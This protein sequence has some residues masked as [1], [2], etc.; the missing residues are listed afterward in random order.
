[1][2]R[3]V[4]A[5]LGSAVLV[6]ACAPASAP[7]SFAPSITGQLITQVVAQANDVGIG[8]SAALDSSGN[9]VVTSILATA[10]LKAGSLPP[11]IVPGQPQPPAVVLAD[12]TKATWNTTSVTPQKLSP[13]EGTAPELVDSNGHA[14]PGVSTS[15][16]IDGQGKDHVV[17]STPSGLF[18]ADDTGGAFGTPVQV[19]KDQAFEGSI[20]VASDGTVWVSFYSG[21]TVKVA[22]RTGGS[23]KTQDV[24]HPGGAPGL[25]AVVT[26]IRVTQGGP[27]VAYGDNGSTVVATPPRGT[28][29]PGTA[30]STTTIAGSGGYGVS[31]ALDKDGNPIVTYYDAQGTIHFA[32]LAGG[33]WSVTDLGTTAPGPNSQGNRSWSTSIAIDDQG[34]HYIAWADTKASQIVLDTDRGGSFKAETVSGGQAGAN[35]TLAVSGMASR[36]H[37]PGTTRTTRTLTWPPLL[38]VG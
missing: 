25:P 34:V 27:V 11:Q 35:P 13:A 2:A 7:P 24:A 31:M 15:L 22:Q 38:P 9:P 32:Q 33:S 21:T 8:P 16:A 30:W 23:W 37:W 19:T 28:V 29:K 18:Y 26:A 14:L 1:M 5:I 17:W 3:L 36:W 20:A 6:A 4:G 10:V 12:R